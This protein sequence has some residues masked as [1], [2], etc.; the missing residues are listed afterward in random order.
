[1]ACRECAE[2][3]S[4]G[5]VGYA[6]HMSPE[7]QYRM[8]PGCDCDPLGFLPSPSCPVHME[9]GKALFPNGWVE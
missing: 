7:C 1:M 6:V 8:E 9:E 5:Y 3:E 2:E 4:N